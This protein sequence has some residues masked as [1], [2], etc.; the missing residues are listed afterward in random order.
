MN[1]AMPGK[2]KPRLRR[3][4]AR[5]ELDHEEVNILRGKQYSI[6]LLVGELACSRC[7][8]RFALL[9]KPL[10]DFGDQRFPVALLRHSE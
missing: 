4:F 7:N 3:M 6:S 10:R 2:L 9:I 5:A 1:P 8:Q